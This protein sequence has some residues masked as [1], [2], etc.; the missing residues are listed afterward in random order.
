MV[1]AAL[2]QFADEDDERM[3]NNVVGDE[4]KGGVAI[5]MPDDDA[6]E[7]REKVATDPSAEW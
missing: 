1:A 4:Q 3:E 2:K 5:E 7:E 6:D